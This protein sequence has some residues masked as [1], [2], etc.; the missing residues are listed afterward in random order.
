MLEIPNLKPIDV[1]CKGCGSHIATILRSLEDDE[2]LRRVVIRKR[3]MLMKNC[4]VLNASELKCYE[5]ESIV[6]LPG[7]KIR[8]QQGEVRETGK[9]QKWGP[10]KS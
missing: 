4:S 7:E 8:D 6:A 5:C 3:I 1:I 2:N 10:L 9:E